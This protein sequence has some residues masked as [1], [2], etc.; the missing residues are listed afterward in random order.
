MNASASPGR[1]WII[2]VSERG[3]PALAPAAAAGVLCL[4]PDLA[5]LPGLACSPSTA[6]NEIAEYEGDPQR[7]RTLEWSSCSELG[8]D[9]DSLPVI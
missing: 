4:G 3:L 8:R 1:T 7:E 2:F 9:Y 5:G 6:R